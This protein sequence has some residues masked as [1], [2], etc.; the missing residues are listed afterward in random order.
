MCVYMR[1]CILYVLERFW[2]RMFFS[3]A[4]EIGVL[5]MIMFAGA[6]TIPEL[7]YLIS[8]YHWCAMS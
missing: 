6:R 7:A 8:S 1:I 3:H 5:H 2:V 4:S